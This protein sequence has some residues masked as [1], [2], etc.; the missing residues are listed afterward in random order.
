MNFTGTLDISEC[1][2]TDFQYW[3]IAPIMS[4][5]WALLGELNKVLPVSKTRFVDLLIVDGSIHVVYLVGAPGERVSVTV[6]DSSTGISEAIICTISSS[7]T[8]LLLFPHGPCMDS[9]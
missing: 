7:G 4:D 9:K 1:S 6:Y 3:S 8:S 2:T 5:G